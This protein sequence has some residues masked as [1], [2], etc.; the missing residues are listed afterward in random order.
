MMILALIIVLIFAIICDVFD[1]T[2]TEAGLAA[3]VA[4]EGN[5]WLVGTKPTAL[6]LYFRDTLVL[7]LC[8]TPSIVAYIYDNPVFYYAFL[9]SPIVF[10]IKH[11]LGG[12][13]WDKLLKAIGK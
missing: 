10:G 13:A 12:L 6:K 1:V 9:I 8:S 11:I 5:T 7:L 3:G 2:Q 4:V